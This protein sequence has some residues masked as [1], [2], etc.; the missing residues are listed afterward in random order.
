MKQSSSPSPH[1]HEKLFNSLIVFMQTIRSIGKL[2]VIKYLD[3]VAFSPDYQLEAAELLAKLCN[4]TAKHWGSRAVSGCHYNTHLQRGVISFH[5]SYS[6]TSR[7]DFHS[8]QSLMTVIQN[9]VSG[10]IDKYGLLERASTISAEG[11]RGSETW[12]MARKVSVSTWA[13]RTS[14]QKLFKFSERC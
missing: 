4:V 7:P 1:P 9:N 5:R 8:W 6:R 13:R 11:N 3:W 12:W 14:G 10:Y 2:G